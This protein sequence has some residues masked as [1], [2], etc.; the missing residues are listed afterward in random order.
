[1]S[2]IY[3]ISNKIN[4]KVYV[5][6]TTLTLEKRFKEHKRDSK[7]ES[8]EK[9]PLYNAMRKYGVDSFSIELL[10][11]V[12]DDFLNERESFWI[13]YYNSYA[14]GY[15]ATLGG[16]GTS[17][18]DRKEVINTY[19]NVNS[20]KKTAS[21]L[22]IGEKTVIKILRNNKVVTKTKS[23]AQQLSSGKQ[24]LQLCKH[25][26]EVLATFSCIR[27]A[28]KSLGD[29]RKYR[30]ISAVCHGTRKTAYGFKWSFIESH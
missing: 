5:G 4:S 3:K 6:K 9:R 17:Y 8:L 21:I 12:P 13:E 10:E 18:I 7:K 25:S 23:E 1:M 29:Y 14:N 2:Y 11:E 22:G 16:D 30:H 28:G 24:V 20:I 15:N 26:G 19:L 27:D